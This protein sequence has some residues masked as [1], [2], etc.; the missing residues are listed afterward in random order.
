MGRDILSHAL[1]TGEKLY[2]MPAFQLCLVEMPASSIFTR[3][4]FVPVWLFSGVKPS[5]GFSL[6]HDFLTRHVLGIVKPFLLVRKTAPAASP[7]VLGRH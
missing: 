6:Q 3:A 4:P 2:K 1:L 7:P 5:Y